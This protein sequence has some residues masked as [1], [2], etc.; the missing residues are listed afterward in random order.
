MTD[1]VTA[2]AASPTTPEAARETINARIADKAWGAR[3]VAGDAAAKAELDMLHKIEAGDPEALTQ[4]KASAP[5]AADPPP[6]TTEQLA[7]ESATQ[8]AE[9]EANSLLATLRSRFDLNENAEQRLK[10]GEGFSQA[11]HDSVSQYKA[12]LMA[13]PDF[14]TRLLAGHPEENR[15][16]FLVNLILSNGVKQEAVA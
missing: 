15:K 9:R 2:P 13:D 1:Q 7:A 16:L 6:K 5:T 11:D 10:T 14:R 12:R 4:A 3:V 8:A